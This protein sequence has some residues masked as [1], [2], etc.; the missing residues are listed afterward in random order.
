MSD[1][2][3]YLA[4]LKPQERTNT[5]LDHAYIKK[6]PQPKAPAPEKRKLAPHQL[7]G[8]Q[9]SQARRSDA[10][11]TRLRVFWDRVP[12]PDDNPP[13][14]TCKTSVCCSAFVIQ[15]TKQEYD[16]GLYA[17]NAVEVKPGKVSGRALA[18]VTV[19]IPDLPSLKDTG[20]YLE[21]P[22]GVSCT[23]L[24]AQGECTIYEDR[25]IV[26][27]TYSCVSDKRITQEHRDGILPPAS[28]V[29]GEDID[30]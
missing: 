20:Y 21:G 29:F 28:V 16:S 25:P 27:R 5:F 12:P 4:V 15:L 1:D 3:K 19:G 10:L 2:K 24:G 9:A 17:E 23:F 11:K 30:K 13:C 6:A 18:L 8:Q 22:L 14:D 26:C 7:L